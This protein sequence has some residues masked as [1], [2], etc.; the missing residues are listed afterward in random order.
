MPPHNLINP[1]RDKVGRLRH[2]VHNKPYGDMMS[3]CPRNTNHDVHGN[4]LPLL[5]RNL[6]PL[7]KTTRLKV[8]CLNLLTIRTPG[9][10]LSNV[11]LHAIPQI[12]LIEV[13]INLGGTLMYRIRR[14]MGL[15]NYLCLEIMHI[16]YTQPVL[17]P[18]YAITSQIEMTHSLLPALCP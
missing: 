5:S 6:N 1:H 16:R 3:T 13:M 4:V 11:N 8:L 14:T 7:S 15:F 2:L 12:D 18:K 17:L 9:H 10:I